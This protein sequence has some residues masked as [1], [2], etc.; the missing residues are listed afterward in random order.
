MFTRV[1]KPKYIKKRPNSSANFTTMKA[2]PHESNQI[3]NPIKVLINQNVW[4]IRLVKL[5]YCPTQCIIS[6]T[7]FG[8]AAS[9]IVSTVLGGLPKQKWATAAQCEWEWATA[10]QCQREWATVDGEEALGERIEGL[11]AEGDGGKWL[12]A[13]NGNARWRL[14]CNFDGFQSIP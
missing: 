12:F 5:T 13:K 7:S 1:F 14:N 8:G 9:S 10:A 6:H 3:Q 2:L 4:S 11:T